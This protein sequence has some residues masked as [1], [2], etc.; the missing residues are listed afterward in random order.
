MT[1]PGL[2]GILASN[3]PAGPSGCLGFEEVEPCFLLMVLSR[4]SCRFLALMRPAGVLCSVPVLVAMD[5]KLEESLVGLD[6]IYGFTGAFQKICRE[7]K[8]QWMDCV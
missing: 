4:D 1:V 8:L 3:A 2:T 7:E 6:G 5:V